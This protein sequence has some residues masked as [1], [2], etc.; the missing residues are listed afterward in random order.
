MTDERRQELG[1]YRQAM[2]VKDQEREIT[3]QLVDGIR[4]IEEGMRRA[5]AAKNATPELV[6]AGKGATGKGKKVSVRR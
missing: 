5:V 4:Q 2:T 3:G 6:M 1:R